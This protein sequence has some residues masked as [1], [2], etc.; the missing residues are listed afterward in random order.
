MNSKVHPKNIFSLQ[1]LPD[2]EIL[3]IFGHLLR[4]ENCLIKIV[5]PF[6]RC[7]PSQLLI[8]KPRHVLKCIHSLSLSTLYVLARKQ[9]I[10]W[11]PLPNSCQAIVQPYDMT[12]YGMARHW[13]LGQPLPNP[14]H[15]INKPQ[16]CTTFRTCFL[17]MAW[18]DIWHLACH[19]MVSSHP[20]GCA[21][22]PA[23]RAIYLKYYMI[24]QLDIKFFFVCQI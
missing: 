12:W 17:I 4:P 10:L 14:S 20:K 19:V 15:A 24:V 23:L 16:G 18:P 3:V 11:Q 8:G 2:S 21:R 7:Q 1:K 6:P 5:Q 13:I 9:F 22:Y